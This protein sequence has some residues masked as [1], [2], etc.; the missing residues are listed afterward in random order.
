MD[1]DMVFRIDAGGENL[2][3]YVTGEADDYRVMISNPDKDAF[4]G[5]AKCDWVR[6]VEQVKGQFE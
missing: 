4:I 1:Q 6:I 2:R 5:I 3:V